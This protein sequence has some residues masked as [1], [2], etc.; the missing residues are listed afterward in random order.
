MYSCSKYSVTYTAHVGPV[1]AS[2]QPRGWPSAVTAV[3]C[4]SLINKSR[5]RKTTAM[6][7]SAAEVSAFSVLVAC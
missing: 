2:L 5:G 6:C 1:T 7:M 3:K 4:T